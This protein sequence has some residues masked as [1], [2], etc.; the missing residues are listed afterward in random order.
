MTG[1][2]ISLN[3]KGFGFILP[4][5]EKRGAGKDVFFHATGLADRN[6]FTSLKINDKVTYEMDNTGERPRAVQVVRVSS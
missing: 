5:T 6:I 4:D 2:I 1:K 3:E